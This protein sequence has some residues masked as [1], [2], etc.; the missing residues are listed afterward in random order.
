MNILNYMRSMFDTKEDLSN[1]IKN[2]REE[3]NTTPKYKSYSYTGGMWA[4]SATVK[5]DSKSETKENHS[6]S[7]TLGFHS[8]SETEGEHS[9]S[10]TLGH[11]SKSETKGYCS[12]SAALG[13][14]SISYTKNYES[15]SVTFKYD[16]VSC[17]EGEATFS[18]ALGDNSL[19]E[20]RGKDSIAYAVGYGSI[21]KAHDG[22]IVIA[23]Y[24]IDQKPFRR[25]KIHAAQVGEK[26]LDVIIEPDKYYGFDQVGKFRMF[27]EEEV[28]KKFKIIIDQYFFETRKLNFEKLT[29][30]EL[31]NQIT[32]LSKEIFL[33]KD[34]SIKSLKKTQ[35]E[36][37]IRELVRRDENRL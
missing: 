34:E 28:F 1:I 20:T 33:N 18:I 36:C 10:A 22:F 2:E 29:D 4:P 30:N 12:P 32:L 25:K 35:R 8:K 15:H 5:S 11:N 21:V 13:E 19:S 3:K 23:E 16:S 17:T 37:Y 7:A 24:Y 31:E 9:P 26:I 6:P 14:E 27:T